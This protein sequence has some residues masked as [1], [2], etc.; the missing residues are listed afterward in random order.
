MHAKVSRQSH[1]RYSSRPGRTTPDIAF[2]GRFSECTQPEI[3]KADRFF[4]QNSITL[5]KSTIGKSTDAQTHVALW[6]IYERLDCFSMRL[7]SKIHSLNLTDKIAEE[8]S[9]WDKTIIDVSKL[10][11]ISSSDIADIILQINTQTKKLVK[12][13]TDL[14]ESLLKESQQK[15]SGLLE[16][17]KFF[18]KEIKILAEKVKET[19]RLNLV[20]D[21]KIAEEMVEIFGKNAL[22]IESIREKVSTLKKTKR[23]PAAEVLQDAL[24]RLVKG[25]WVPE[26]CGEELPPLNMSSYQNTLNDKFKQ[27][28]VGTAK[29]ILKYFESR[30][31]N[32]V[33][34]QTYETY[35]SPQ[36]LAEIKETLEKKNKILQ[37]ITTQ[38]DKLCKSNMEL[39]KKIE[40]LV[41]EKSKL[42]TENMMNK[43]EIQNSVEKENILKEKLRLLRKELQDMK[44]HME[45]NKSYQNLPEFPKPDTSQKQLPKPEYN[46]KV[47]QLSKPSSES[48]KSSKRSSPESPSKSDAESS[49]V[50][51]SEDSSNDDASSI[52]KVETKPKHKLAQAVIPKTFGKSIISSNDLT[53]KLG[54]IMNGGPKIV[55]NAKKNQIQAKD[56][57]ANNTNQRIERKNSNIP[58]K[59]L[60]TGNE[61][62]ARL[63]RLFG[64]PG[65][66]NPFGIKNPN[67]M[68]DVKVDIG[69][70]INGGVG[71][72]NLKKDNEEV[73]DKILIK[74]DFE[75]KA[76]DD[77][78]ENDIKKENEE[79]KS[80]V[81]I[82]KIITS[83]ELRNSLEKFSLKPKY[84]S[85]IP[86]IL[87]E[88]SQSLNQNITK[89]TSNSLDNVIPKYE[90]LPITETSMRPQ[91]KVIISSNELKEKLFQHILTLDKVQE[92]QEN[93]DTSFEEMKSEP[94]IT[95]LS[96]KV[97]KGQKKNHNRS[98]TAA[99]NKKPVVYKMKNQTLTSRGERKNVKS[100]KSETPPTKTHSEP[101]S[102]LMQHK[103]PKKVESKGKFM[104]QVLNVSPTPSPLKFTESILGPKINEIPMANDKQT[105]TTEK[106]ECEIEFGIDK[107]KEYNES[108]KKVKKE[109][110]IYYRKEKKSQEAQ[111]EFIIEGNVIQKS[112]GIDKGVWTE[113]DLMKNNMIDFTSQFGPDEAR[114]A[115]EHV[116]MFPCNPNS[117]YGLKAD[118][119]YHTTRGIF[120]PQPQVL[121]TVN[122]Y[123]LNPKFT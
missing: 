59:K 22:D 62:H 1:T 40:H 87:E 76:I 60:V 92:T 94:K 8:M 68:K 10:I 14:Y 48:S 78:V 58:I 115:N 117:Y 56:N 23:I 2:Y 108:K 25:S 123:I 67:E 98:F 72:N 110:A 100:E 77:N 13:Q 46:I 84:I 118:K 106:S 104:Y 12:L 105:I 122:S 101:Q 20:R 91:I 45:K 80:Q 28:Q 32:H 15:L 17:H 54:K 21:E 38:K 63:S 103:S 102:G 44:F 18:S 55:E 85:P 112:I 39:E 66:D 95:S 82:K 116:Y 93:L 31:A 9:N 97:P 35:I 11:S 107:I 113:L 61:V 86:A 64:G 47:F 88:G 121:K 90:T 109:K 3:A 5:S 74:E 37:S 43:S 75:S 24:E 34:T 6:E 27:V 33:A 71:S 119:Y 89:S 65:K 51:V 42:H 7:D 120:S 50:S 99:F 70:N 114:N 41:D 26:H 30:G 53:S 49:H 73:K 83:N 4:R 111:T 36:E 52:E 81:Q 57:H 79:T 19:D 29:K 69:K 96:K 16:K